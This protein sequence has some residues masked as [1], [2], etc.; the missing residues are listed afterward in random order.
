MGMTNLDQGGPSPMHF[1]ALRLSEK[2]GSFSDMTSRAATTPALGP[3]EAAILGRVRRSKPGKVFKPADFMDLANRNAIDQGL[4]RLVSKGLLRRLGRGLYDRPQVHAMLGPLLPTSDAIRKALEGK[5]SA[6]RLQP[7][8]A[9]A[10]NLMGLSEQ[11]PTRVVFLTDGA[12]RT[13]KV[14]A[15]EI[16]LRQTTPRNMATAGRISGLV[17]QALRHLGKA[18][19]DEGAL[20]TL[21]N[22][23][24]PKDKACL[25]QDAGYA[26][27]WIA[28]IL[29]DLAKD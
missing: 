22:R 29:Q 6:L 20:A 5:G 7:S 1:L 13:L 17:I 19:L 4:S 8:G 24:T 9:Y 18:H 27:A 12:S 23:L 28:K 14:G 10:A 15:Q 25:R 16:V 2:Q 3:T 26:P 11:V 21:R